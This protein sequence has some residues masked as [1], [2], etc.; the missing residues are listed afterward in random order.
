MSVLKEGTTSS[1][2][3]ALIVKTKQEKYI[4]VMDGESV[5]FY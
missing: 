5:F 3:A 2:L 1:S 4:F